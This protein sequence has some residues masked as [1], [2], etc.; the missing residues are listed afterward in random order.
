MG[1]RITTN[2]YDIA[3]DYQ[4]ANDAFV[5]DLEMG[6]A[7]AS[8]GIAESFKKNQL[9]GRKSDNTGLNVRR[10]IL[11]QSIKGSG[12]RDGMTIVGMVQNSMATYWEYHQDGTPKLPKRLFF[13]EEFETSGAKAYTSVVEMA[14]EKLSA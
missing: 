7:Q 1:L 3:V 12:M 13:Y 11:R 2:A 14:M 9:S 4:K 8:Q 5:S 6:F 10:D